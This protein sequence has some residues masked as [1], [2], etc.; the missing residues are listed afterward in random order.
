M[1]VSLVSNLK[2]VIFDFDDTLV[3]TRQSRIP[4]LRR[5][6]L[7]F[8]YKLRKDDIEV[9]WGRPFDEFVKAIMPGVAYRDFFEEYS[10]RLFTRPPVLQ[11]GIKNFVTNLYKN[12]VCIYVLSSGSRK[13]VIQD[14]EA[15]GM[16]QFISKLWGHEDTNYC[17]PDPRT[18]NPVLQSLEE[19]GIQR[20]YVVYIGDSLADLEISSKNGLIFIAVTTGVHNKIDF[21][22][23]GIRSSHIL[24]TITQLR[25]SEGSLEVIK[26]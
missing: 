10:K 16:M 22:R 2:A 4:I 11:S 18:L 19:K 3:A 26:K 17:K 15:K 23:K 13:L 14:L 1:R 5:L 21:S 25:L 6:A 24:S 7:E 20:E 8:G 9:H 12:G